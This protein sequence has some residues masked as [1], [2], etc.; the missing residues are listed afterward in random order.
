M[1]SA[2]GK[3]TRLTS[4]FLNFPATIDHTMTIQI[5]IYFATKIITVPKQLL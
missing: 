2:I 4:G 5:F 3:Q 1:A